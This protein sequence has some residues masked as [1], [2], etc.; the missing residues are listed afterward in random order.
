M[1]YVIS[2]SDL[3]VARAVSQKQ[4]CYY[5]LIFFLHCMYNV[6]LTL[7]N[8]CS[9]LC[10]PRQKQI[11]HKRLQSILSCK[12]VIV[13]LPTKFFIFFT[14]KSVC[15]KFPFFNYK[16]AKRSSKMSSQVSYCNMLFY[17]TS[18]YHICVCDLFTSTVLDAAVSTVYRAYMRVNLHGYD[19]KHTVAY[20]YA[21]EA[22]SIPLSTHWVYK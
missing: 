6:V 2:F 11:L 18:I 3:Q 7:W 15:R 5:M 21:C 8:C 13:P 16:C 22:T 4:T 20:Y 9:H 17:S 14:G 19:Q 12:I 10:M 1:F